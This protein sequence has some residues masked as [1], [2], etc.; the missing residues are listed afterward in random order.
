MA[1]SLIEQAR[2][3][4]YDIPKNQFYPIFEDE[5]WEH[6]LLVTGDDPLKAARMAATSAA[7]GISCVNSKE[8]FGDVEAWNNS[9]SSYLKAVQNFTKDKTLFGIVPNG[10]TPYAAGVS[11]ADL[12]LSKADPDNPRVGN[13]LYEGDS[14]FVGDWCCVTTY[15]AAF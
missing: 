11:V 6:F 14:Y 12:D 13:V 8:K 7:M 4:I 3:Y 2:L 9:W 1:L 10:V 5:Y 15:P